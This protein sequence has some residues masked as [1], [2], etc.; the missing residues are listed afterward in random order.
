VNF[1]DNAFPRMNTWDN[2]R[3][4]SKFNVSTT[5]FPNLKSGFANDVI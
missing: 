5:M 4:T 2:I 1:R 3:G